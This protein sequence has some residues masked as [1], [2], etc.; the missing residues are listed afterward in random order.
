MTAENQIGRDAVEIAARRAVPILH[1]S[2]VAGH[3]RLEAVLGRVARPAED[4]VASEGHPPAI[5][6]A[7]HAAGK[8]LLRQHPVAG[9]VWHRQ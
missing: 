6:L 8:L 1:R 5:D 3:H 2:G 7:V 9:G 4:V